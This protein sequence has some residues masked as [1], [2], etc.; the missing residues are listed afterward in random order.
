MTIP[1]SQ[2]GPQGRTTHG[3]IYRKAS[4]TCLWSTQ[5]SRRK[6]PRRWETIAVSESY[7]NKEC[8]NIW[9]WND[10]IFRNVYKEDTDKNLFIGTNLRYL[11]RKMKLRIST[12]WQCSSLISV[13]LALHLTNSHQE[14]LKLQ[15]NASCKLILVSRNPTVKKFWI[16]DLPRACLIRST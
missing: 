4:S 12:I 10:I 3:A 15:Q 6:A 11:F 16:S 1:Q 7:I 5:P 13:S 8:R 9:V 2:R 14:V